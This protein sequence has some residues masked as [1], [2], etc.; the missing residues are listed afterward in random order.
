[1]KYLV[2]AFLF[3]ACW[4]VP[5]CT[6]DLVVQSVKTKYPACDVLKVDRGGDIV[7]VTLQCPGNRILTVTMHDNS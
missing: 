1:M 6:T 5:N 4:L 2:A 3:L 7:K